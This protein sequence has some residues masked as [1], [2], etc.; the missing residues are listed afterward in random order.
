MTRVSYDH[1]VFESPLSLL[2]PQVSRELGVFA[3]L[4]D[5][6]GMAKRSIR[7]LMRKKPEKTA[8]SPEMHKLMASNFAAQ[9]GLRDS[10]DGSR[11]SN[12]EP[13]GSAR[14]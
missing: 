14:R 2:D 8:L 4:A 11:S 5:D 3:D 1:N 9:D 7:D 10:Q 12:Q 13:Q 6:I